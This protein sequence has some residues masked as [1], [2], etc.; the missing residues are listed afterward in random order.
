MCQFSKERK[1][2]ILMSLATIF[3]LGLTM[4]DTLL[5]RTFVVL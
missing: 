5:C 1:T 4:S 3:V 2:E